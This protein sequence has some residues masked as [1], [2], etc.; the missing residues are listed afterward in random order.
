MLRQILDIG[1]I[2]QF[3]QTIWTQYYNKTKH[4]TEILVF[5]NSTKG[6]IIFEKEIELSYNDADSIP[7]HSPTIY[8]IPKPQRRY[9]ADP[10]GPKIRQLR[11]H[12]SSEKSENHENQT[13]RKPQMSSF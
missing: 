6:N 12:T 7:G 11:D 3:L 1:L 13:F 10:T 2:N 9:P 5:G 8:R 4:R